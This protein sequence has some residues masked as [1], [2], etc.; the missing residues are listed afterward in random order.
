[1]NV[2]Y[3]INWIFRRRNP[4]KQEKLRQ[5]VERFGHENLTA[6]DIG[7]MK[8][9]RACLNESFRWKFHENLVRHFWLKADEVEAA[10]AGAVAEVAAG[11]S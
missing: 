11:S 8:Y 4:E 6:V 5:E 9:F 3:A 2:I 7:H 1:M 10:V